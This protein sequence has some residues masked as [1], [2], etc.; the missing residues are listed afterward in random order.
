[1]QPTEISALIEDAVRKGTAYAWWVLVLAL[2]CSAAGAF[3]ASY[4]RRKGEDK[5]ARE[6]FAAIRSQLQTTTQDT[7]EIKQYLSRETWREQRHWSALEQYYSDLLTHL[8]AFELALSELG[9][10]YME[11][12]SEHTPDS[13]QGEHFHRLFAASNQSYREVQ[14]LVGPAALY[15]S[16]ATVNALDELASEHWHLTQFSDCTADYVANAQAL[17][18]AA[19]KRVLG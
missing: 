16:A 3:F 12:G 19:Y 15:L 9:D 18:S 2:V 10:H 8:H 11:P 5:A 6:N 14:K 13:R 1:M 17:A 7:E 4:L